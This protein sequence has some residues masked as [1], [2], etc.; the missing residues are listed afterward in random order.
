VAAL[1]EVTTASG[2]RIRNLVGNYWTV[3]WAIV[4]R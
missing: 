1:G 4:I 2:D 3:G